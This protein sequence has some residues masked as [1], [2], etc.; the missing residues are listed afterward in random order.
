M[1]EAIDY[2]PDRPNAANSGHKRPALRERP[3]KC[4]HFRPAEMSLFPRN[5]AN[6]LIG[7]STITEK[8]P[9]P[10][11]CGHGDRW[12]VKCGGQQAEGEFSRARTKADKCGHDRAWDK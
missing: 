1:V 8:R 11:K 7:A 6:S 3:A 10:A 9:K 5:Q 12:R 4:G 2:W